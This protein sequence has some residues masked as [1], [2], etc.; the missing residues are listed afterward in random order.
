M[1][2]SLH[3]F[4][5]LDCPPCWVENK[6][7]VCVFDFSHPPKNCFTQTCHNGAMQLDMNFKNL[8]HSQGSDLGKYNQQIGVDHEKW[9]SSRV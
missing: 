2:M 3:Y 4:A 6:E 9:P 5:D 7:G 8:F 1:M